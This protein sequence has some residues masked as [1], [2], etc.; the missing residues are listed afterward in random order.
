MSE[1]KI[2]KVKVSGLHCK[3]C[4]LLSEEKLSA[5]PGVKKVT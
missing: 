4:E 2:L 1:N 3:A 5:L